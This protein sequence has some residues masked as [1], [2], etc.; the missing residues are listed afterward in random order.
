MPLPDL[1]GMGQQLFLWLDG[2][3]RWLS[4]GIQSCRGSG[5]VLAIQTG[6]KL[7]HLPWEVLHDGQT[8]LVQR[9]N[10]VVIP[11]RWVDHPGEVGDTE[12]RPLRVLFMA[13]APQGVK[14]ALDFEQEEGTI[15]G[16]TADYPITLR[17]EESGCVAELGKLWRRYREPF[18]VFHLTGHASINQTEPYFITETE[19]GEPWEAKAA[20][21]A[22]ALQFRFPPLVFLSGC[23]TG[24]AGNQG[25]IS[26][27]A[28]ALIGYGAK[29]VLGWGRP[30]TD[31]GATVAA[32]YLYGR[33]AAGFQV[34]EALAS[35]YQK[36]LKDKIADWH[37]LRLYSQGECPGALVEP[38][39]DAVWCAPEPAYSDFLDPR[40][41]F[42]RVATAEEFVG[43]RRVLQRCLRMLRSGGNLGVLMY[44]LGGVG[45]SSVAARLLERVVG[46]DRIVVYRG[47]DED[48]L[49]RLFSE[50]CTSEAGLEILQET[51]P[52]MQ[53]L[54]KFFQAGL[55][56]LQQRFVVVL[57][58]FEANL[59]MRGDGV[60]VLKPQVV[61][62]LQALLKAM[63]NSKLPHRVIITS[64]YDFR[65]GDGMLNRRL[66]RE[67]LAGLQ[68]AD[69]A[70]KYTRLAAFSR[71]SQVE[72]AIQEKAKQ[73][74]DG[75]P[76]L[77]EW[78][79]QI[80]ENEQVDEEVILQQMQGKAAEFRESILAEELLKQQPSGVR[81]I[82]GIGLVYE[83]PV[84]YPAME[85]VCQ[86]IGNFD[87]GVQR[88]KS[89]GLLEVSEFQ[90]EESYRVSRILTPLLEIPVNREDLDKTAAQTLY[91]L[92]WEVGKSTTEDKARE[93]HRLALRG[94]LPEM[95]AEI[96][97]VLS[98]GWHKQSRFR[99]A[100]QLCKSTLTLTQDYRVIHQL[101]RAEA[102]LGEVS[103]AKEHYQQAL[104]SCPEAE[105][106]TKAAII[107][108]LAGNYLRQGEID[109]AISLYQQSLELKRRIGNVQ[110]EAATLHN[111]AIIYAQQGEIEEAISLYQQSMEITQQIGD[112]EG[113]ATALH[114]LADIHAQQGEIE[115]AISLY[116]QSMEIK[117]RI[118][119]VQGEA[120]TLNKLA[121]IYLKQGHIK[122]AIYLYQQSLEFKRRI[123]NVQ[124]EAVTLQNLAYIHAQQGE[125]EEAISLYKQSLKLTRRIGDVKTEATA[126]HN[127][128]DIHAQ[129]GEIEKAIFR[130]QQ[131]M[132]I[133][134]RIR[135]VQG[136]AATLHKLA[137]IHAQQGKID[138]AISLYQQSLD[139][140]RRIGDVQG[141]AA[142]LQNLAYIHAQKREIDEAISLYQQSLELKRRIGNVQGE[143]ATLAWL[144]QLLADEKGEVETAIDY[145]QQSLAI[146]E[147]LKSP[148]AETVMRILNRVRRM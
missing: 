45:K 140:K 1:V 109:E 50:Q 82:L 41:Q 112:V 47:L 114:N 134:K 88:A 84:P 145:L 144:G 51:L 68:G 79:N 96:A 28:E 21:I 25:A 38:L 113:A 71:E 37:L 77:L 5:L 30:V 146:L 39:G 75:N 123:G 141:E 86:G 10:P 136:E 80:L 65:L 11:M 49:V 7:A 147:H 133:T 99:E 148:D 46:Y 76:R 120:A 102:E 137:Y 58:D 4:R 66:H 100:L 40:T 121:D 125:I 67:P 104:A 85:A 22:E 35:T 54:T 106:Q 62:V 93:I 131:S 44:G 36:L 9:V 19:T 3:G 26:S 92:W 24:E 116:Q 81:Q 143:A 139:I 73:V 138:E 127:L 56:Q 142:T 15:L 111:L 17:V 57:D 60:A 87:N 117:Q 98:N 83:L 64:R 74:A 27:L 118:G 128:A 97:Q 55:N 95:A 115:Q 90:G 42:I 122:K 72:G 16:D 130:Y 78:L 135:Y 91:H 129:Q 29:A 31:T 33:L 105:E 69:L 34:A 107:H 119:D 59:E 53:R 89:L 70:K 52:L 18:D 94:N 61:D 132:E 63:V 12:A 32:A 110:G 124:G 43:R 8:F 101:A 20:E 2:D 48:K 103:A 126:L 23:R 14:P 108:N 6:Q 13:T